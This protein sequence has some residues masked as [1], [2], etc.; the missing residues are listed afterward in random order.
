MPLRSNKEERRLHVELSR[1]PRWFQMNADNIELGCNWSDMLVTA[2]LLSRTAWKRDGVVDPKH[3]NRPAT[4]K[5]VIRKFDASG[6]VFL[7]FVIAG[8]PEKLRRLRLLY[9]DDQLYAHPMERKAQLNKLLDIYLEA[10]EKAKTLR[11]DTKGA[12]C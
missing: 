1:L 10:K 12:Q 4:L 3:Q 8:R 6:R 7:I 9:C 11:H 5:A 2:V